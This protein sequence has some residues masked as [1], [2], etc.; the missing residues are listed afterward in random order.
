[1]IILRKFDHDDEIMFGK[2]EPDALI[3]DSV[4]SFTIRGYSYSSRVILSR[5]KVIIESISDNVDIDEMLGNNV[6]LEHEAMTKRMAADLANLLISKT[7]TELTGEY[8]L[9]LGFRII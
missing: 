9:A 7:E 5:F 6:T 1:M 4:T 8:L 3:S 2:Y